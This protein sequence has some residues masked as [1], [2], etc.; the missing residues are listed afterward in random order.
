MLHGV[1]DPTAQAAWKPLRPQST[2][3]QLARTLSILAKY[4]Q[5]VSLPE[6]VEMLAG[7]RPL[8]VNSLALTFD[9]GYRNNLTFALP[10][11]RQFN[12]PATIF[13][14]TGNVTEQKPFW[15]DRLDY[16]VQAISNEAKSYNKIPELIEINF[17][18]RDTLTRSFLTFLNKEAWGYSTDATMRLAMQNLAERIEQHTG[19]GL[20]EIFADDPWSGILTWDEVRQASTEVHFGSHCVDHPR[21]SLISPNEAMQELVDSRKVIEFHTGQPCTHLAYPYG[22]FNSEVISLAKACHYTSAVTTTPGLNRQGGDLLSL[23]RISF[24]RTQS[25]AGVIATVSGYFTLW[26]KLRTKNCIMKK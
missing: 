25:Q 24:P 5:F 14:S 21:L 13:L 23:K 7:I 17:S 26:Q 8:V 19:H 10:I 9:D 15:F 1:T 18:N 16:A 6:A 22:S 12:A 2:P 3:E 20:A 4:Y 11:L